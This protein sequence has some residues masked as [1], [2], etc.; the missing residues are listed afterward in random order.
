MREKKRN[1]THF[2]WLILIVFIMSAACQLPTNQAED[3]SPGP[4]L[5][6][7]ISALQTEMFQQTTQPE[8]PA[9]P[10]TPVPTEAA[11]SPQPDSPLSGLYQGFFVLQNGLF[12]AYDFN[13]LASGVELP[14]GS[15]EWFGENQIDAFSDEIF[16][17][18]FNE[19]PGAFRVNVQGAQKLDFID[20]QDPVYIA[21]SSEKQKIAW[22]TS[23]WGEGSLKTE[24]FYANLDGSNQ[25]L[26]DDITA[27]EQVDLNVNFF[28]VRWT[29]DGRLIYATGM[30]GIGGYM[31]YWGYNGLYIFNPLNNSIRTLVDDQERLGICLSSISDDL[32]KIAIVCGAERNVRVRTIES[33]IETSYPILEDQVI[34]GAARFSPSGEWLAYVIQRADPEQELGKIVV[35]PVDGS[36]APRVLTTIEGGS[37]DVEGWLNEEYLLV[38]RSYLETPEVNVLKLS[39]DGSV[40]QQ[41]AEGRFMDFIP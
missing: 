41:I 25:Q 24:I 19:N 4:D 39:R 26:I 23:S 20:A 15:S 36:Q 13:G 17:T 27:D 5:E 8:S 33:G 32:T 31:L 29:D 12:R 40:V 6:A 7:T 16:Y 2:I 14:A 3:K 38:T 35:V 28:P 18:Q 34:A 10:E 1:T 37:F 22:S 11:N 21:I 30:T 9:L